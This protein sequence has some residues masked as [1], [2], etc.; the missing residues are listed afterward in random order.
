M[1]EVEENGL[2]NQIFLEYIFNK[3]AD[4][5]PLTLVTIF[6]FCFSTIISV[7]KWWSKNLCCEMLQRSSLPHIAFRLDPFSLKVPSILLQVNSTQKKTCD[8]SLEGMMENEA[9]RA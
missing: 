7:G 5:F 3:N 6:I 2:G 8:F 9:F 1:R 4:V